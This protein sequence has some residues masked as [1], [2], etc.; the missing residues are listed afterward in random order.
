[1]NRSMESPSTIFGIMAD[2]HC[3]PVDSSIAMRVFTSPQPKINQNAI[4]KPPSNRHASPLDFR[5]GTW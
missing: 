4:P 2:S 1:M 5:I 3:R